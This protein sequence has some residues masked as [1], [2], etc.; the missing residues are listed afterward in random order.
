MAETKLPKVTVPKKRK[1]KQDSIDEGVV[2]LGKIEKA[3]EAVAKAQSNLEVAREEAKTA[4]GVWM[5]KVSELR[6]LCRT[7]KRW[8]AEAKRQ[9]LFNQKKKP[10]PIDATKL[11]DEW[12]DHSL[13]AAAIKDNHIDA[14]ESAGVRTL[15]DLQAKMNQHGQF[16]AKELGINGRYRVPIEDD[17]NRYLIEITPKAA[18]DQGKLA[19]DKLKETATTEAV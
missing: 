4:K 2:L 18:G 19:E 9:P 10:A 12:K 13:A 7:R 16:W 6:D 1:T 15:G 17:F 8:A 14:L 5:T 3:E 11:G